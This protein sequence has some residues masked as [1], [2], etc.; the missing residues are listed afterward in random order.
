[1]KTYITENHKYPVTLMGGLESIR[2]RRG[3]HKGSLYGIIG[4]VHQ[5]SNLLV[6]RENGELSFY[7]EKN[8]GLR[9]ISRAELPSHLEKIAQIGR[10]IIAQRL[11]IGA[12]KEFVDNET[13]KDIM[14]TSK[15]QDIIES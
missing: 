13:E 6:R 5:D 7:S 14:I 12:N 8:I 2:P 11:I 9:A 1:M 15:I 3:K 4:F 10:I